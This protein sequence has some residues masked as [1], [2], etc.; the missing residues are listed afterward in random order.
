MKTR[1]FR[2]FFNIRHGA[3]HPNASKP[4]EGI[5]IILIFAQSTDE[6]SKRAVTIMQQLPYELTGKQHEIAH[7]DLGSSF[8]QPAELGKL[9]RAAIKDAWGNGIGLLFWF[10]NTSEHGP[11]FE[12]SPLPQIA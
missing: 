6:A 10:P 8:V 4:R 11:A 7:G 9:Y 1:L 5:A 3:G 12:G 2:I